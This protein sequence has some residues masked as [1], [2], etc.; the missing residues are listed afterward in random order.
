VLKPKS[1][2]NVRTMLPEGLEN[3]GVVSCF[4][5]PIVKFA[6]KMN[7]KFAAPDPR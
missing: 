2:F 7:F 1:R 5:V 3:P 4:E 6:A